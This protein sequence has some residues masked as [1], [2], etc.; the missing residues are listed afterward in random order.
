MERL[1]AAFARQAIETWDFLALG[2]QHRL[3]PGEETL[4]DI[5]L[6]RL[7]AA[8][9][10]VIFGKRFSRYEEGT[11]TGSDWEW[12]F[13]GSDG[14]LGLRVQ[15]KKLDPFT[16]CYETVASDWNKAVE[17]ANTL[18]H[19]ARTGDYARYPCYCFYNHWHRSA[20]VEAPCNAGT[21]GTEVFGCALAPAPVVA[22]LWTGHTHELGAVVKWSIPWSCL[23]CDDKPTDLLSVGAV[24]R[25]LD[26]GLFG[27]DMAEYR[28]E[29]YADPPDYVAEAWQGVG[30][31]FPGETSDMEEPSLSHVLVTTD[32]GTPAG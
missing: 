27:G 8:A 15:A 24:K 23:F 11:R 19:D 31:L 32:L 22:D 12:W 1:C 16:E 21:D 6:L 4:T 29:I 28:G 17:Q 25:T 9:P 13:G 26:E 10:D 5:N 2:H 3:L 14:W 18:I 7:K 30:L 20:G